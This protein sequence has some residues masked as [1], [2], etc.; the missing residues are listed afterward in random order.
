[1]GKWGGGS[2]AIGDP[3]PNVKNFTNR[4]PSRA[5]EEAG[6]HRPGKTEAPRKRTENLWG[7]DGLVNVY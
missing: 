1:M 7:L 5:R 3:S 6:K 4:S 2:W